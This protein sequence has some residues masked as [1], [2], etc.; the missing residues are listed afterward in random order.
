MDNTADILTVKEIAEILRCSR[1]HVTNVLAGKV[2]GVA[3]LAYVNVG[4]R[5]LV[6]REWFDQWIE[7]NKTN[8][9]AQ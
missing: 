9:E 7:A 4:R 8:W 1:A 5:K 6:R 2:R 3:R